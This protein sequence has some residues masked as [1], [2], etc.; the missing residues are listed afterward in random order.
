MTAATIPSIPPIR[1]E[2]ILGQD[3]DDIQLIKIKNFCYDIL[4]GD[5]KPHKIETKYLINMYDFIINKIEEIQYIENLIGF[6][7]IEGL[8]FVQLS[9][10]MERC[11]KSKSLGE[12][13]SEPLY[14]RIERDIEIIREILNFS[15]L[16]INGLVQERQIYRN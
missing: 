8:P 15:Y 16:I 1:Y 5:N 14:I 13:T 10:D 6:E 2:F 3:T 12:E 11:K 4:S 9:N 7:Q